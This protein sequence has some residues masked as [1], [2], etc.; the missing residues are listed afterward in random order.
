MFK[1]RGSEISSCYLLLTDELG[2]PEPPCLGGS[3]ID[4]REEPPRLLA[5]RLPFSSKR[6]FHQGFLVPNP[7]EDDADESCAT[8]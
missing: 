7:E 2:Q 3:L 4:E 8:R 6:V 1:M 5:V